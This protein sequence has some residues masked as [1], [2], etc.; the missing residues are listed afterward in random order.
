MTSLTKEQLLALMVAATHGEHNSPIH[1]ELKKL[2]MVEERY[3]GEQ[4]AGWKLSER[5]EA[6]ID[7]IRHVPLP[8]RRYIIPYFGNAPEVDRRKKC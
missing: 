8:E 7:F 5:G 3:E 6:W 2:S 4:F 1:S